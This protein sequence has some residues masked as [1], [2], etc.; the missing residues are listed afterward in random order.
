MLSPTERA[1]CVLALRDLAANEIRQTAVRER[2][3]G[4]PLDQR[5]RGALVEPPGT[6]GGRGTGGHAANDDKT[7]TWGTWS[8]HVKKGNLPLG[9]GFG[10]ATFL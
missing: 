2:H 1:Q 9:R 8:G 7:Q 6:S 4:A 5:D 10:R 3:V